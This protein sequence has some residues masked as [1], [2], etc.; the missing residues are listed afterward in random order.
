M[1]L[2]V[3]FHEHAQAELNEAAAYN[4]A[5]RPGLGEPFL[6]EI[7]RAIVALAATPLAGVEVDRGIRWWFVKKFPYRVLCRVRDDH[8]RILAIAHQKRRPLYWGTRR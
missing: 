8:I 4:E 1:T 3:I 5:T 7:Q 6:A 2:P